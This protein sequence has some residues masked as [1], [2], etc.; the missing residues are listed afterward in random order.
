MKLRSTVLPALVAV[1]TLAAC[2][3]SGTKRVVVTRAG[4]T[5]VGTGTQ[6]YTGTVAREV[7]TT[8]TTVTYH[9]VVASHGIVSFHIVHLTTFRSPTGNI[10]CVVLF[11]IARCDIAQR[12]W[13]PPPHPPSCSHEV[14]F[15]QGLAVGHSGKGGFVCAGDTAL[16][17]SGTPLRYGEASLE[18]GFACDSKFTG[19]TCT[20]LRTGHGFFISRQSYRV[21]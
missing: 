10:G 16:D 12:S 9:G 13:K 11:G 14:D 1:L 15:G 7:P 4:T 3:S 5:A 6:T 17:P 18:E 20:N 2:G 19:M 8:P 21:F